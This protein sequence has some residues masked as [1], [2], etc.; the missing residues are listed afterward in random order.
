MNLIQKKYFF[1]HL[2]L[3]GDNWTCPNLVN[4]RK[5]Q[6]KTEPTCLLALKDKTFG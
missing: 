6:T 4:K 5:H 1:Y 3:F 2:T